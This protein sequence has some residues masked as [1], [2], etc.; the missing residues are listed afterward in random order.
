[1]GCVGLCAVCCVFPFARW[2]RAAQVWPILSSEAT[3]TAT[4]TLTLD[5]ENPITLNVDA[6][7]GSIHVRPGSD[8]QTVVVTYTKKAYG[9]TKSAALKE[10]DNIAITLT[11]PILAK[12]GSKSSLP[13]RS[14]TVSGCWQIVRN[15]RSAYPEPPSRLTTMWAASTSRASRPV[16]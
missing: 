12:R 13:A 3:E 6:T 15:W 10:L 9:L 8:D 11:Q 2:S 7:L 5:T 1:M 16:R 14:K 4:E